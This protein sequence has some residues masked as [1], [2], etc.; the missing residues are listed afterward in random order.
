VS[1]RTAEQIAA[2]NA[3]DD[4]VRQCAEAYFLLA[5]GEFVTTWVTVVAL[6]GGQVDHEATVVLHPGGD[7]PAYAA[8][9]LLRCGEA[10]LLDQRRSG[11]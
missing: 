4:A 3:L 6:A 2:D 5:D 1:D 9:G 11:D 7:Q 10:D 8:I